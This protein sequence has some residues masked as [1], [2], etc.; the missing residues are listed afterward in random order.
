MTG[1]YYSDYKRKLEHFWCQNL[2]PLAPDSVYRDQTCP[3]MARAL[4]FLISFSLTPP[5]DQT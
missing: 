3:N 4:T 5:W 1:V 2:S